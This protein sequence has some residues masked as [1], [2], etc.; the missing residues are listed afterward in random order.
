MQLIFGV[1]VAGSTANL[2]LVDADDPSSV[3]DQSQIDVSTDAVE[4][5]R[6]TIVDTDRLLAQDGHRLTATRVSWADDL[7]AAELRDNLLDSGVAG[8]SLVSAA[9]AAT[10]WIRQL[11]ADTSALLFVNDDTVA[12]SVVGPD[13]ATTSVIA[14][15]PVAAGGAAAACATLLDRF[16]REPV[17]AQNVYVMTSAGTAAPLAAQ[18]GAASPLPMRAVEEPAVA[19]ARG[20]VWAM[21]DDDEYASPATSAAGIATAMSPQLGDQLAY[22]MAPDS[23]PIDLGYSPEIDAYDSGIPSQPLEPHPYDPAELAAAPTTATPAARPRTMLV[24]STIAAMVMTGFAVLAVVV[25]ISIQPTASEQAIRDYESVPGKYLPVMPGQGVDAPVDDASAYL[26]PI[27]PVAATRSDPRISLP[28]LSNNTA[29]NTIGTNTFTNPNVNPGVENPAVGQNLGTGVLTDNGVVQP[30]PTDWLNG[31][32]LADWIPTGLPLYT[33]DMFSSSGQCTTLICFYQKTGCWPYDGACLTDK[34]G[35]TIGSAGC[36]TIITQPICLPGSGNCNDP[37][38]NQ[39]NITSTESS[40][41]NSSASSSPGSSTAES[42]SESSSESSTEDS[43]TQSSPGESTTSSPE[44]SSESPTTESSTTESSTTPPSST[45][46][47]STTPPSS[48]TTTTRPP[49]STPTPTSTTVES[50]VPPTNTQPRITSTTAAPPPAPEPE[51][52]FSQPALVPQQPVTP[53]PAPPV[54]APA[55][56]QQIVPPTQQPVAPA[57]EPAAPAPTYSEPAPAPSVE[58]ESPATTTIVESLG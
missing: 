17:N 12:L 22:S 46:E 52:T 26:P 37:S 51:E 20:A 47:S 54:Q 16:R 35:C 2:A 53:E 19:M 49:S 6:T 42:S 15:E 48:T 24:G 30:F 38:N 58:I 9:D 11:D 23:D 43:S 36:G 57:P 41:S 50:S 5:L 10:A 3:L 7:R 56:T 8:V 4:R 44:E 32:R 45:T 34:W 14:V 18:L 39:L 28:G 27:V 21:V 1:S 40:T 29:P 31:F 55:P 33:G 25:A 13:A